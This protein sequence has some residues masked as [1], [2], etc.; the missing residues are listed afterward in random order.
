MCGEESNLIE[1]LICP[2]CLRYFSQ[3]G[4]MP[5]DQNIKLSKG[6]LKRHQRTCQL[7]Y[8]NPI[9]TN[10]DLCIYC[11]TPKSK[12]KDNKYVAQLADTLRR[13]YEVHGEKTCWWVDMR[14]E[15]HPHAFIPVVG[16]KTAGLIVVR[17]NECL[18]VNFR[19][20][21]PVDRELVPKWTVDRLWIYRPFRRQGIARAT[22]QAL[23]RYFQINISDLGWL[24]PFTERGEA[25]IYSLYPDRICF[26][27]GS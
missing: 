14:D 11:V 10:N 23:L 21:T 1:E 13:S 26:I 17:E 6:P 12:R 3:C 8:T 2:V 9:H 18:Q 27:S 25:F 24:M 4:H 16:G 20:L 19:T 5:K 22:V 15:Y 7:P